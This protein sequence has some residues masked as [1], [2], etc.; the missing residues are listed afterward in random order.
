VKAFNCRRLRY[1]G[2]FKKKD[3]SDNNSFAC[4]S[5]VPSAPNNILSIDFAHINIHKPFI[6]SFDIVSRHRFRI[7]YV[8]M[9]VIVVRDL[10]PSR[11]CV[12]MVG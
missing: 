11:T 12:L 8:I 2:Y 3:N 4:L 6:S 7:D 10:Y 5:K 9:I 1:R